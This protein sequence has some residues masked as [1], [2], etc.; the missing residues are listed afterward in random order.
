MF[1]VFKCDESIFDISWTCEQFF[2]CGISLNFSYSL[3]A[4]TITAS[5]VTKSWCNILYLLW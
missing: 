5:Y 1:L 2:M 3:V 4:V